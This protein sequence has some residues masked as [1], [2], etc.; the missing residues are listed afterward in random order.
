[1]RSTSKN[2]ARELTLGSLFDGIGGWQLA[3]ERYGIKPL[4]SSEIEPFCCFITARQFP[5][6]KQLGDIT[7]I[8]TNHIA[9]PDILCAGSPCQD[10]S[11]AGK[12]RGLDGKRSGLFREAIRIARTLRKRGGARYFVWENVPGAFSSNHGDDF[13]AVLEE[14]CETDVPMPPSHKWAG[15]GVVRSAV[16]DVCWR[17]LDSQFFGVPQFRRRIFLVADYGRSD[18]CA[19]KILL[20]YSRLQEH[21]KA[22]R[23]EENRTA[24][25]SEACPADAD[26]YA[27]AGN[28]I[29]RKPKNG[30]NG[31]GY[32]LN[33][34]YTLNTIDRHA[35]AGPFLVGDG[36]I[37]A[38]LKQSQGLTVRRFTPLECERLQ[39]LPEGW[40]QDGAEKDRLQA[41]GNGMAQ[42]CADFVMAGIA[43]YATLAEAAGMLRQEHEKDNK[44]TGV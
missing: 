32:K 14:I 12:R 18:R 26:Y 31:R 5:M 40:T 42:P 36:A 34:C 20:E 39:G 3:A 23:A 35:L 16:C 27:I 2:P 11:V 38:P 41:L 8:D 4:W 17:V 15:A 30:G 10:L 6:T 9:V 33:T 29:N 21:P 19:D 13:R 37:A 43:H 28:I 24:I 25:A 1:M 44:G 7:R 22:G